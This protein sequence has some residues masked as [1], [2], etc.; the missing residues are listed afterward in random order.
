MTI[1]DDLRALASKMLDLEITRKE[2]ADELKTLKE[3]FLALLEEHPEADTFFDLNQGT[4]ALGNTT[5]FKIPDGLQQAVE[6]HSIKPDQLDPEII[7]TFMDSNLKLNKQ[8]IKAMK[9]GDVDLAN[10]IVVE[11]K[12]KVII[13]VG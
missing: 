2:K 4:V 10:L 8:G 1:N 9:E 12:A 11:E 3:E 6:P 5:S 7:K 13:K